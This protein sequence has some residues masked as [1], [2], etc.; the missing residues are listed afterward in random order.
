[1]VFVCGFHCKALPAMS[2][3]AVLSLLSG[4]KTL[5]LV[6]IAQSSLLDS[7]QEQRLGGL[8][9]SSPETA[10]L[11]NPCKL[12]IAPYFPFITMPRRLIHLHHP[13]DQRGNLPQVLRSCRTRSRP[14]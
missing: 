5:S 14:G 7:R 6:K 12:V 13:V 1:M 10:S 4:L 11:L 2:A 8:G 3:I 9:W